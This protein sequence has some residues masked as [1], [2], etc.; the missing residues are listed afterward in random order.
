MMLA[1]H[2][3]VVIRVERPG[4]LAVP[5]DPLT[6]S[7]RSL[8]VNLKTDE[9][10]AIVRRLAAQADGLV[11]GYRPGVMERLGL[12]PDELLKD[13]PR[14]VYGRVTGWG[15][16]GPLAAEAGHDID[17]LALTGL[18]AGLG[19]KAGPPAAPTIRAAP[20]NANRVEGSC[21]SI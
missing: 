19:P 15:Q 5:N 11:E 17:Y 4:N 10:V 7:R 6:R 16:D 14:L 18:L 3:A 2:G 1:D 13:N 21:R 12:G 9:G 20:R 8:A